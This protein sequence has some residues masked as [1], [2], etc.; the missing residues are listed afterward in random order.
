MAAGK[1]AQQMRTLENRHRRNPT[2]DTFQSTGFKAAMQQTVFSN[3]GR[4]MTTAKVT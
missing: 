1:S 2:Y 3:L 4:E